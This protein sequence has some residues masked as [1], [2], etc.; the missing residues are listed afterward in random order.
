MNAFATQF[1]RDLAISARHG[2]E[3]MNPIAFFAL[4]AFLLGLGLG[5]STSR[6]DEAAGGALWV[7]ALFANVLAAEGLFSRDREDGSLAH[8]LLHAK[9]LFAALLGKV[10]AH[11]MVSGLPI[12]ALSPLVA[13]LVDVPPSGMFVLALTLLLGTP[14]LALIGAIGAALVAGTGR[15]GLLVALLVMPL[16]VPTLL[17]GSGAAMTALGG[18]DPSAELLWLAALLAA[19]ITLAPF[20]IGAALRVGQEY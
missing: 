3:A 6:L 5:Q 19:S 11:W 10:A 1:R 12:A 4:A 18:G 13:L 2:A 16:Y 7:L 8:L 15:G 20:G 9:P 17:F 14:T